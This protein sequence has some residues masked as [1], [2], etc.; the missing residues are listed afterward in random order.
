MGPKCNLCRQFGAVGAI[1][2]AADEFHVGVAL[3]QLAR[4]DLA[5]EKDISK[6]YWAE[7]GAFVVFFARVDPFLR[8]PLTP[9][10]PGAC[11]PRA[12]EALGCRQP[13]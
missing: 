12:E 7:I 2:A 10:K 6:W 5:D 13:L 3:P 1:G 4:L 11:P 8:L 9:T